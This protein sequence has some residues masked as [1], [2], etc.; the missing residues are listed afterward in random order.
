MS[1]SAA[2]AAVT[3]ATGRRRVQANFVYDCVQAGH[4]AML[5]VAAER[6]QL[7]VAS[8]RLAAQ[9]LG[10]GALSVGL[11]TPMNRRDPRST[12]PL[13]QIFASSQ[14][15]VVH[16]VVDQLLGE[17]A[18]LL[19]AR[20]PRTDSTLAH[21]LARRPP[22]ALMAPPGDDRDRDAAFFDGFFA[23]H[24]PRQ[25]LQ[26]VDKSGFTP[27]H[28]LAVLRHE[29]AY[30]AVVAKHPEM[31]R[32]GA[33]S[34]GAALLLRSP[35]AAMRSAPRAELPTPEA[36]RADKLS[37]DLAR[38]RDANRILR[39]QVETALGT[40][41]MLEAQQQQTKLLLTA[42]QIKIRELRVR[43][44][45]AND[46][47][48]EQTLAEA[49]LMDRDSV[50]QAN[51]DGLERERDEAIRQAA[52]ARAK[53]RAAH[54]QLREAR[55]A[56]SRLSDELD[57][58]RS[59]A[60][61]RRAEALEAS[62]QRATLAKRIR[63]LRIERDEAAEQ[64]DSTVEEKEAQRVQYDA[65]LASLA[66]ELADLERQC[67]EADTEREV[68]LKHLREAEADAE[69][70]QARVD[71]L[72]A[73]FQ[74]ARDDSDR[75]QRELRAAND[76]QAEMERQ[77]ERVQRERDELVARQEN[78]E[79]ERRAVE[80]S[81]ES[82]RQLLQA[83]VRD[84]ERLVQRAREEAAEQR[85]AAQEALARIEDAQQYKHTAAAIE[86][87]ERAAQAQLEEMRALNESMQ[88]T[89]RRVADESEAECARLAAD[90]RAARGAAERARASAEEH[91]VIA[92]QWTSY[93]ETETQRFRA[94][95]EQKAE[96]YDAARRELEERR[97]RENK[98]REQIE[99]Q[100]TELTELRTEASQRDVTRATAQAAAARILGEDPARLRK[101]LAHR[102]IT[103]LDVDA[104]MASAESSTE[105]SSSSPKSAVDA[106]APGVA[107]AAL[108]RAASSSRRKRADSEA[109]RRFEVD[110]E[111]DRWLATASCN[112]NQNRDFWSRLS[113]AVREG[114]QMLLK[115]FFSLGVSPNS[116]DLLTHWS[117]LE[118]AVRACSN[119]HQVCSRARFGAE[120]T[121]RVV[122][123]HATIELLIERGAEWPEIDAFI[124]AGR[125]DGS[126]SLPDKTLEFIRHRDDHSPFI[127]ALVENDQVAVASLIDSVGDLDRVPDLKDK[128]YADT[129]F[130][131]VHIAIQ[132]ARQTKNKA[133]KDGT[134]A[135]NESTL[136]T[137][138]SRG[139]CCT[140]SDKNGRDPLHLAL[141]KD[142][143]ERE[144]LLR[145]VEYLM[146]GGADPTEVCTYDGFLDAA[147]ARSK[148][149]LLR[150]P[151]A[152]RQTAEETRRET[153][154]M[155]IKFGTP[156]GFAKQRGDKQLEDLMTNRRYKQ[157]TP[158]QLVEYI[159][160]SVEFGC[161]VD[162]LRI[163]GEIDD[164][165]A[166][167][168]LCERY[169]DTF[170][171]Y[172]PRFEVLRDR[173]P[174]S[175]VLRVDA[176]GDHGDDRAAIERKIAALV[177]H[178][179]FFVD[180]IVY[181]IAGRRGGDPARKFEAEGRAAPVLSDAEHDYLS[182]IDAVAAAEVNN[183][184][185]WFVA[186][187]LKKFMMAISKRWFDV[188]NLICKP[189][190]LR[191][192][193]AAL[194]ALH[195]FVKED[196]CDEMLEMLG[197]PDR[198]YGDLRITTIVFEPQQYQCI[199]LAAH[200]GSIACLE[201]LLTR[202]PERTKDMGPCYRTL[203][204]VADRAVQPLAIVAVDK[205]DFER[206]NCVERC[207]NGLKYAAVADESG[208]TVLHRCLQQKVPRADLFEWCVDLVQFHLA[209]RNKKGETP[210]QLAH[211]L[212]QSSHKGSARALDAL[213]RCVRIMREY[214]EQPDSDTETPPSAAKTGDNDDDDEDSSGET[215]PL[216][217]RPPA[218]A[219][220]PPL[221]ESGRKS[222]SA[223]VA[224]S[225]SSSS[226]ARRRKQK[227]KSRISADE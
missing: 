180:S 45:E 174:T 141:M 4:T 127:Q 17:R 197:R 18:I 93:H 221:S 95:L 115:S 142:D 190:K 68:A 219:Q 205:F 69:Q 56:Q 171:F 75:L 145:I 125:T 37:V 70:S 98:L 15:S 164:C 208:E 172:N 212:G 33:G 132:N 211:S 159:R 175:V 168:T 3:R 10:T 144:T 162:R 88:A 114:D 77:L 204:S 154:E 140:T 106:A 87:R 24:C 203:V 5:V 167:A 199:D 12:T 14:L 34:K 111:R 112:I 40:Q 41:D 218:L 104:D 191:Y 152:R 220:P 196:R 28:Y 195:D 181:E 76:R 31:A 91:R 74:A 94:D 8:L 35:A 163:R 89:V 209:T 29:A 129:G 213:K 117:L 73:Q 165:D 101:R 214:S 176:G 83:R 133:S 158:K 51:I 25:V 146:A 202:Q 184:L 178:D 36:L 187:T 170:Q 224:S 143:I 124:E 13:H 21:E 57:I 188:S 185:L 166:M 160:H 82:E 201:A 134:R 183:S 30:R 6:D 92:E 189:A 161:A 84:S 11:I 109:L 27:L 179:E 150:L 7:T 225:S 46:E 122:K 19:G 131:L 119:A 66:D 61:E 169:R 139:A 177:E 78:T 71:E 153:S 217:E 72:E 226:S 110:P 108:Q 99:R 85:V 200:Y 207:P 102:H 81:I 47:A 182:T 113:N 223:A 215:G 126:V 53:S 198:L 107:A 20:H 186:T 151:S 54:E 96:M 23:R 120:G 49:A 222:H 38:E 194:E 206:G 157:V 59:T 16:W 147:G 26:A 79:R 55:T 193:D 44:G 97:Q 39:S 227:H 173:K 116:R 136:Y 1:S 118:I 123:L 64:A 105:S 210:P 130:S 32:S 60:A 100:H 86:E 216:G 50:V 43:L 67:D 156:V 80:Q 62:E 22:I 90:L 48:H 42:Q 192:P 128:R 135:A 138:V 58:M 149:S 52:E 63:R 9:R 137:L 65:R 103:R 155:S 2:A 148:K 121:E